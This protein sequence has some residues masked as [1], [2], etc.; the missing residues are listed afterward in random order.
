VTRTS[1]RYIDGDRVRALAAEGLDAPA[2]AREMGKRSNNIARYA[3]AHGIYVQ[4]GQ[5]GCAGIGALRAGPSKPRPSRSKAALGLP[6][7]KPAAKIDD[8]RFRELA[9]QG[10]SASE[11]G[12]ILDFD[13]G[14][15]WRYA[16]KHRIP[17][18]VGPKGSAAARAGMDRVRTPPVTRR[19]LPVRHYTV[20]WDAYGVAA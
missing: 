3:K 7:R 8:A 5:R 6:S 10:Y 18:S 20:D 16:K 12:R 17:I 13:P 9:A 11:I 2:I 19:E 4:P 15:A 1:S 14:S